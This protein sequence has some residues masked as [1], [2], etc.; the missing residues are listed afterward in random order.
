MGAAQFLADELSRPV[1]GVATVVFHSVVWWYIR[2]AERAEIA[3]LVDEAAAR[4]TPEAPLAWLRFEG[5]TT[6]EAELR[7]SLWPRGG[8]VLLGTAHYHGRWVKW[9]GG[10]S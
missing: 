7:L 5:A 6:R 10:G 2:E 1:P 9:S 8:D 3:R 4:A